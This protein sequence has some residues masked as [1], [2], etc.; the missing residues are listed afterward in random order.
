MIG[1]V[2]KALLHL[3]NGG[4]HFTV[5]SRLYGWV[6]GML[7]C[8]CPGLAN[9]AVIYGRE[10]IKNTGNARATILG[11]VREYRR[12]HQSVR[13]MEA[14][15]DDGHTSLYPTIDSTEATRENM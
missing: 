12:Q 7:A 11:T 10:E 3:C 1:M 14:S 2:Y 8:I 9:L 4:L 5:I 15:P 13:V 6:C